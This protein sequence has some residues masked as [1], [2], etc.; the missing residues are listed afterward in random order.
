MF[1]LVQ[2][3]PLLLSSTLRHGAECY[4][5]REI[6]SHDSGGETRLTYVEADARARRLASSLGEIGIRPGGMAGGLAW[7]THRY[8][9]LFHAVPG[10]GAVLHTA[11]PRQPARL[12]AAAIR[13][14]GYE[15]L[16]IDAD[17]ADLAAEIL[18]LAP[19]LKRFVMLADKAATADLPPLPGLHW[20]EDLIA[21]GDPAFAWPEFDER[22]ASTLCFTSGTTGEPKGAL[23]SH[24]GTMLN[25]LAEASPNALGFS[26]KDT[27]LAISP[28]FHCNG[29]GL[30]Y[31][32]PMTG[33]S[34]V[35]PGRDL[36]P[37]HIQSLIRQE[38][39]TF[40]GAVPTVW[41]D[42]I[43]HCRETG[44]DLKPLERILS[45][46]S[47]PSPSLIQTLHDEFGVQT[48]HAWG[49]TETT[50]GVVFTPPLPDP[51]TPPS[52]SHGYAQGRPLF[53]ARIRV[54]D[55]AGADLG[56]DADS[57]GR[58][59]AQGHWMAAN[60]FERPDVQLSTDDGWMETG[61]L[62]YITAENDMRLTDREKDAIKSG[63]EWISSQDL[64]NAAMDMA[65]LTSA[66]AIGATHPRWIERPILI[67]VK[68]ESAAGA[69]I[70]AAAVLDH[71]H[72]RVAKWQAPDRVLFVDDL[73]LTPV[74]KVDKRALKAKYGDIL[75]AETPAAARQD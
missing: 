4:G 36:T 37:A 66:A 2:H 34:L 35:L 30:P 68:A 11:N 20:Q 10:I 26:A 25:V 57:P 53:G 65:G 31:L 51:G 62:G 19:D 59:Q 16:F 39:V 6:V 56:R 32:A 55:D 72:A 9:E 74:G 58:L 49:M 5:D 7:T 63:G 15:T 8:L 3:H 54:V 13:Q 24:R 27:A 52:P 33:A 29:W 70:D 64:E 46:G 21:A 73:P 61:D 67:A 23:Y 44:V 12:L 42:V 50:H 69:A 45:G 22:T 41:I 17:T 40:A 60:Y 18:P 1:G 48:I 75:E 38:G 28:F 47:P 14:C 71:L 43:R